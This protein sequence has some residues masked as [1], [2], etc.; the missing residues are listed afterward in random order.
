M[1]FDHRV[2]HIMYISSIKQNMNSTYFIAIKI[3]LTQPFSKNTQAS[4]MVEMMRN[5]EDGEDH[6]VPFMNLTSILE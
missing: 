3:D 6:Y 1:Q 4:T 5:L 2:H